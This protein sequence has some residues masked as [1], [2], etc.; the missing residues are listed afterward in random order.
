MLATLHAKPPPGKA[1]HS[2]MWRELTACAGA[3]AM[4]DKVNAAPQ[5]WQAFEITEHLAASIE[6][7]AG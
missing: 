2:E 1:P 3:P 6:M 4:A 5:S 7:A